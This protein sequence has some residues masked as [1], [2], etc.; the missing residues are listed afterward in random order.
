MRKQ[1]T[2]PLT[3]VMYCLHS[4]KG[5]KGYVSGRSRFVTTVTRCLED[6]VESEM[7]KLMIVVT[8]VENE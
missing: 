8:E 4:A 1:S 5:Q 3:E 7:A 2:N 6:D